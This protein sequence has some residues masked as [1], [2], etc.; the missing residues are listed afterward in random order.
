MHAGRVK[1]MH[2]VTPTTSDVHGVR[3]L[4]E[5]NMEGYVSVDYIKVYR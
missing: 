5:S 3:L 1:L 4:G 2:A